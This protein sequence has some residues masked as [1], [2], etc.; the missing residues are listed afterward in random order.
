MPWT[1]RFASEFEREFLALASPVQTELLARARLLGKFGP[2][3]GRPWA[4]VLKGSRFANMK[5]LRFRAGGGIWRVAFAFDPLRQAILLVAGNKA[6]RAEGRFY[7]SLIKRA[8]ARYASH[9]G[10][11]PAGEIGV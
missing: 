1:V 4:D 3:T 2:E 6:G 8:D 11:L 10:S 9:L 5:E 7:R